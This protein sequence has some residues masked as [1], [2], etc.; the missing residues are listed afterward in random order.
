MH[1][2]FIT[3]G[4]RGFSAISASSVVFIVIGFHRLNGFFLCCLCRLL[5]LCRPSKNSNLVPRL[6]RG[7]RCAAA[8]LTDHSS[9][10][11]KKY[12]DYDYKI[13]PMESDHRKGLAGRGK[14]II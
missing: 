11:T 6:C 2:Y 7:G 4:F 13:P 3:T 1:F 8:I 12:F 14:G 10:K 9:L 5:A